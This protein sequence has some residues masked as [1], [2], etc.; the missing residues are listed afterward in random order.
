MRWTYKPFAR[1]L[2]L[3]VLA[4]CKENTKQADTS[5]IAGTDSTYY[6]EAYR[7]QFHFSPES[8][9]MNDPNGLV[10]HKGTYHLFYQHYPQDIVWGPM[11]WGHAVSRDLVFW[12]HKP[13]ALYPDEHGL[14]FSGSA[15]IDEK[16]TSGLGNGEE[17]PMVAVYTYHDMDKEQAGRLD[18]QTQGIAY[19]LDEGESWIKYPENPVIGND[20]IRDFRDPKVFWHE[21]IGKW[22]MV[23]VAGDHAKIYGSPN[24][25]EWAHLSDFGKE[26]GAHGGVWE[27]PD[28][29]ELEE[30]ETGVKKWVLIISINPG[31]PNGGSG[32]QYFIGD[33]NGMAFTSDQTAPRWLDWGTDNYAGVTFNHTPDDSRIFIG[34]MSNWSYARN[35]PTEVWRSAMTVP[36]RLELKKNA[37]GDFYLSNYPLEQMNTILGDLQK[38]AIILAPQEEK[39]L[40]IPFLNQ[41]EVRFQAKREDWSI[42]YGSG[43]DQLELKLDSGAFILDRTRSGKTDFEDSFPSVQQMPVKELPE[44]F[45][46]RILTDW[47]SVEV[48]LN[49]GQYVMTAQVFPNAPYDELSL[50]NTGNATLTLDDFEYSVIE[51]IWGE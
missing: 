23:L 41:S 29:F 28:L 46:V 3:L 26:Q 2:M 44:E 48:F 15:V 17:I 49:K 18:F 8:N 47:S 9:W 14:I 25:K 45:E 21:P 39:Q 19:S 5:P 34:W 24:L 36:R 43:E 37:A 22:I 40:A 11:H 4:G 33:F 32:T 35:T 50:K 13:I 6:K 27:C 1:F 31:A 16:N 51:A 10:Y 12:E 38:E 30:A 20:S 42:A 7:P